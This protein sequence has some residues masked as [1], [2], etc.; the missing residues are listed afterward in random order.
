L[1]WNGT[2]TNAKPFL[3]L[4]YDVKRQADKIL[5]TDVK[6]GFDEDGYFLTP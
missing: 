5:P 6:A 2:G 3:K 4:N 1:G